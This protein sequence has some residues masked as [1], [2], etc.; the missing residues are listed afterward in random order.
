VLLLGATGLFQR[1]VATAEPSGPGSP[2]SAASPSASGAQAPPTSSPAANPGTHASPSPGL[3]SPQPPTG[4]PVLVGAGDIVDCGSGGDEATATLLDGIEGTVFT[5]GD[6]AYERGSA[7]EFRDCYEPSWGRHRDRTR[8]APGN[9]DWGTRGLAGYRDY[10]GD[11]AAGPGGSSWYSYELGAWHVIVLDS[12][13]DK[14]DGCGPDSPQGEW[15][16]ADLAASQATCTIAIFHIP[17]FS[18]GEEHGNDPD[19]DAFWRPLYAAGV[20]VIVNG[21]D[22]DYERF[23]P[24][25][26]DGREDRA[27]GIRQFVVGTGGTAL[28]TFDTPVAN[29]ELRASVAHGVIALTLHPS[30]YDWAFISAGNAFGDHGTANCH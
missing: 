20:D 22:H 9:H 19:M 3:V 21:H 23:A 29:S 11:A 6:N 13:C 26:P 17:R 30:S 25:D 18:S 14:V 28:R 2:S 7:E 16:A 24:Q 8:P 1:G 15:L 27:A 4:D 10:F 12:E 5:V